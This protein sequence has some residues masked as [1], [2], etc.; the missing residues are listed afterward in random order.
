MSVS[1]AYGVCSHRDW[2]SLAHTF[3]PHSALV[4]TRIHARVWSAGAMRVADVDVIGH[5]DGF[6]A[7]VG[8]YLDSISA[9]MEKN[10]RRIFDAVEARQAAAADSEEWLVLVTTDHGGSARASMDRSVATQF[11]GLVDN[12]FGQLEC[13]GVHGLSNLPMHS[14]TFLLIKAPSYIDTGGEIVETDVKNSDITPTLLAWFGA[15]HA[16]L[17]GKPRGIG[18]GKDWAFDRGT[19]SW[20]DQRCCV[21]KHVAPK[22]RK[23]VGHID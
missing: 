11:D 20:C 8:T 17:A 19:N 23:Q 10:V 3:I 12:A 15:E 13:E 9:M 5:R 7:H 21:S 18:Q 4:S 16:D 6:G 22:K 2:H 1:S 14:Q